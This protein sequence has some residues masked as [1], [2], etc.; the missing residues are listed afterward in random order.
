MNL[1]SYLAAALFIGMTVLLITACP[2]VTVGASPVATSVPATYPL[3][4]LASTNGHIQ[5]TASQSVQSGG[6]GEAVT[7]V[8]DS[9]CHFVC[10]KPDNRTD[11]PRT[12]TNVT[13]A[14][15]ATAYFAVD[16][17]T[18]TLTYAAGSNGSVSGTTSQTVSPGAD[19]GPVTAV[20]AIGYRFS[21]WSD[22]ILSATRTDLSVVGNLSVTAYFVQ[23][24]YIVLSGSFAVTYES[25]AQSPATWSVNAGA[26]AE[27]GSPTL[28]STTP[29]AL[30]AW[31]LTIPEQAIG[32]TIYFYAQGSTPHGYFTTLLPMTAV[33]TSDVFG[34]S[35][36]FA[37]VNLSGTASMDYNGTPQDIEDWYVLPC[38]DISSP[39]SAL[40]SMVVNSP[41]TISSGAWTTDIPAYD[42]PTTIYFAIYPDP[43]TIYRCP[44]SQGV[45]VHENSIA[46]INL[47]LIFAQSTVSGTVTGFLTPDFV[48]IVQDA[49]T[50][51]AAQATTVGFVTPSGT[52]WSIDADSSL[53]NANLYFIVAS[54][55]SSTGYYVSSSP[56]FIPEEGATDISLDISDFVEWNPPDL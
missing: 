28:A 2:P 22:G 5:G 44:A 41:G 9:G 25:V 52:T 43:T 21:R 37:V 51:A 50:M 36:S 42:S 11:N 10:W 55:G 1:K 12:D 4:Y 15:S 31:E 27:S 24:G 16:G 49:S 3:T 54:T 26:S 35:L 23:T 8:A 7:A 6:D 34:I 20:P 29:N 46:G 13:A 40:N 19:G 39:S 18:Y 48:V 33:A 32:T 17:A 47:S 56:V 14:V 38:T 53:L 45:Q 30:G